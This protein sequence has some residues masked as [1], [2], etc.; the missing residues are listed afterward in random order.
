MEAKSLQGPGKG[1]TCSVVP[2]QRQQRQPRGQS[3]HMEEY[4]AY[5][6]GTR[7]PASPEHLLSFKLP[8][9]VYRTLDLHRR[10]LSTREVKQPSQGHSVSGRRRVLIPCQALKLEMGEDKGYSCSRAQTTL[11]C[12]HNPDLCI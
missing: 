2:G 6:G 11:G 4:P 1:P 5:G 8:V 12:G 7:S 9:D 10:K 3:H